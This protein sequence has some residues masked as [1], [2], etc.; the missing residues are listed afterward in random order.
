MPRQHQIEQYQQW[1][2]R[3]RGLTFTHYDALWQWSVSDLNGFWRS[4]WDY[5]AVESA[6]PV[7]VALAE[8]AVMPGARWFPGAQLNYA[9]QVLRHVDA[10]HAAGQPAIVFSDER[11]HEAGVATELG[12]PELH[13]Q[14]AAMALALRGMGVGRGDR[15]V[16]YLPNVPQTVVAFLACASLGAVW[17][18]CSPDMGPVAVLDRFS[19]IGPRVLI[20]C[21][22]TRYGG[23]DHDRRAVLTR[24]VASL[25]TLRDIVLWR[26]TGDGPAQ[27]GLDAATTSAGL[28]R[29]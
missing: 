29:H 8:P 9:R 21:D 11:L 27:D 26:R 12:W 10:A 16:A 1:L 19:Q 28:G 18:V 2:S 3:E 20:C 15:V 5:F 4:I 24:L 7:D 23:T 17:S 6:T 22:S 25:P 14:V 13:R